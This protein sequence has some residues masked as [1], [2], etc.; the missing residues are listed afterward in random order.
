MARTTARIKLRDPITTEALEALLTRYAVALN[1]KQ[2][3]FLDQHRDHRNV[4][5]DGT[6]VSCRT[7]NVSVR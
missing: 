1:A 5:I 3:E 2:R 6:G 7:C 4:P